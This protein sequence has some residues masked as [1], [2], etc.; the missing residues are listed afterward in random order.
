MIMK[1]EKWV[2]KTLRGRL[3][4]QIEASYQGFISLIDSWSSSNKTETR[5][6]NRLL[7]EKTK[8]EKKIKKNIKPKMTRRTKIR[9]FVKRKKTQ[10]SAMS[11]MWEISQRFWAKYVDDDDFGYEEFEAI[12]WINHDFLVILN[13][14]AYDID[15]Y[16]ENGIVNERMFD[17]NSVLSKIS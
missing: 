9:N 6:L 13:P 3:S 8:T 10:I 11:N 5:F 15:D 17:Y 4:S 7:D 1:R 2:I 14:E 16:I 12:H